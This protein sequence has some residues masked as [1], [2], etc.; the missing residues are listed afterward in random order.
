MHITVILSERNAHSHVILSKRNAHSHV[1]LN[2]RNAHS[3]VI[4]SE[5]SESKDLQIRNIITHPAAARY[6]AKGK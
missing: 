2:E 4:L 1:I 3:H 5:R 6:G